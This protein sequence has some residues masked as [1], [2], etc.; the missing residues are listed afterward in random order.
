MET[1]TLKALIKESIRE[2]LQEE[3]FALIQ[4]LIPSVSD[5]E[6]KEIAQKFGTPDN[7]DKSKFV[8]MTDWLND[9]TETE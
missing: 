2:V 5:Q 6:M 8:D 1:A 4:A 7:Y 9:E 3:R